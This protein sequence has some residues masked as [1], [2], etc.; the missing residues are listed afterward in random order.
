MVA[1]R[2]GV[3]KRGQSEGAGD[4]SVVFVKHVIEA[5]WQPED[6]APVKESWQNELP[7][8]HFLHDNYDNNPSLV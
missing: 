2:K 8:F 3:K 5:S 6:V 1:G 4:G 7:L